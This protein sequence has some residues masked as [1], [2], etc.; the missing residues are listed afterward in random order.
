MSDFRL[1]ELQRHLN[2]NHEDYPKW[3]E[4]LALAAR[5]GE[6]DPNDYKSYLRLLAATL[7]TDELP[8]ELGHKLLYKIR[9][10]V[11]TQLPASQLGQ[12]CKSVLDELYQLPPPVNWNDNFQEDEPGVVIDYFSIWYNE[13]FNITMSSSGDLRNQ[14]QSAPRNVL[15]ITPQY[16]LMFEKYYPGSYTHPPD[17]DLI[18][19]EVSANPLEII[20]ALITDK[21]NLENEDVLYDPGYEYD[22]NYQGP[23]IQQSVTL[24]TNQLKELFRKFNNPPEVIASYSRV[25]VVSED[26]LVVDWFFAQNHITYSFGPF[27]D[28]H[29]KNSK[30]IERK[31]NSFDREFNIIWQ[32][33][34]EERLSTIFQKLKLRT[35]PDRK[36]RRLERDNIDELQIAIEKLR[37]GIPVEP[38]DE[39]LIPAGNNRVE[40]QELTFKFGNREVVIYCVN[41][42]YPNNPVIRCEININSGD[43]FPKIFPW[44]VHEVIP[45][46]YKFIDLPHQKGLEVWQYPEIMEAIYQALVT[47][48][49]TLD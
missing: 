31:P 40:S 3:L 47:P 4:Y 33:W 15:D 10:T 28:P 22:E 42:P 49:I 45:R 23:T 37:A 27:T 5:L 17:S 7:K 8:Q 29:Q 35:N 6:L 2:I 39:D 34:L 18:E 16:L 44:R 43:I 46:N 41:V 9:T 14:W 21:E 30:D 24:V 20:K 48:E 11:G 13:F 32:A 19:S 26:E 12:L 1:R 38:T 36:I 25:T